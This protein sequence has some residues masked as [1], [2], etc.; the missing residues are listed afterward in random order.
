MSQVIGTV[1]CKRCSS[2]IKWR[3]AVYYDWNYDL[4]AATDAADRKVILEG[5]CPSC[6]KNATLDKSMADKILAKF[7]GEFHGLKVDI[8]YDNPDQVE[9]FK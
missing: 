2:D 7:S 4:E 6:S 5:H 9:L 8:I 3:I 1:K